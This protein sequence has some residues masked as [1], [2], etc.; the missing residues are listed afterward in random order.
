MPSSL[1]RIAAYIDTELEQQLKAF[2]KEQGF[3][4]SEA[5]THIL[6]HFL[7]RLPSELLVTP[8]ATVRLD[9]LTKRLEVV[10][11]E[12]SELRS[13][14]LSKRPE[15]SSELPGELPSNIPDERE[16]PGESLDEPP[17]QELTGE[18]PSEPLMRVPDP[19]SEEGLSTL[20]MADLTGVT[21]Q[22]V[23]RIRRQGKLHSWK[24]GWRA[25]KVNEKEHRYY[26][27][28]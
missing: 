19:F 16:P 4:T 11:Q 12:I 7:G 6:N 20:K 3:S 27:A 5:I 26:P 1:P 28:Q 25:L 21:V 13:E 10:E 14:S 24:G 15:V 2:C 18:L 9:D 17:S 8:S 22:Q 23:N